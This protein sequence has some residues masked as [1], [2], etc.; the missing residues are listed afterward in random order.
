MPTAP[1]QGARARLLI[2]MSWS[3]G[4]RQ[5]TDAAPPQTPGAA[6]RYLRGQRRSRSF[7][8]RKRRT[9]AHWLRRA[10]GHTIDHASIRRRFEVLLPDRVAAVRTD[11]VEIADLLDNTAE[12]DPVCVAE[13]SRLLRDGCQSPLYN[14]DLHV[15]ELR[16][17][18]YY[19]RSALEGC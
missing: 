14:S 4:H 7:S 9:L 19:A 15:S 10:A 2:V 13:L 16:A 6:A 12:P 8:A 1:Y 11:L 17:T 3:L 18:L 5:S